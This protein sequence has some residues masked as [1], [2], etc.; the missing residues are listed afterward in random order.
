MYRRAVLRGS[1]HSQSID[2]HWAFAKDIGTKEGPIPREPDGNFVTLGGISREA[3]AELSR[4]NRL[5]ELSWPL[6]AV[7][8]GLRGC[9]IPRGALPRE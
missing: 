1:D 7:N 8:E 2:E 6:D 3:N 9:R 4:S 5:D